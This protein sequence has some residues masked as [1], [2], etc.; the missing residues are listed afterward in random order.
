[1]IIRWGILFFLGRRSNTDIDICTTILFGSTERRRVNEGLWAPRGPAFSFKESS[2]K[3]VSVLDIL[4]DLWILRPA[5]I[6]CR[7]TLPTTCTL[8]AF[9]SLHVG[10][11]CS[12]PNCITGYHL[13]FLFSSLPLRL[14]IKG[15]NRSTKYSV[16][17]ANE[18]NNLLLSLKPWGYSLFPLLV[19]SIAFTRSLIK[20]HI[21]QETSDAH[22]GGN[23]SEGSCLSSFYP[24]MLESFTRY[25]I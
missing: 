7:E 8:L 3:S 1:M 15:G 20:I 18:W 4:I 14:S 2:W 24:H 25:T 16:W 23:Y 21:H 12:D 10:G 19:S 9:V 22:A 17:H 6:H 13:P 5:H 11:L